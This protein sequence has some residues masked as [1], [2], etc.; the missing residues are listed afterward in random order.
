MT[1]TLPAGAPQT[2][3]EA[4]GHIGAVTKPSLLDMKV[5]VLAEAASQTLYEETAKGTDN[6]AV[7]ALLRH[8]G[9]EEMAHAHRVSK[10]IKAMS[11]EDYP[12]PAAADNPYLAGPRPA[13]TDSMTPEALEKLAQAEFGGDALYAGWADHT[14]NAE[15]VA[16]FR[17]NGKEETDHGNRLLEAAKLLRG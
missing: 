12:P 6:A 5:M 3:A 4:F 16:L 1:V 9:R 13:L 17:L 11:G 2:L 14:D 15:A 7:Q 10:A 8:N